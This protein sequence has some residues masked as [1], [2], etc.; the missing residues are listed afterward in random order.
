MSTIEATFADI[1]ERDPD[2]QAD[3]R[4]AAEYSVRSYYRRMSAMEASVLAAVRSGHM[5]AMPPD[6]AAI[7]SAVLN[8]PETNRGLNT[9]GILIDT[10]GRNARWLVVVVLRHGGH[11]SLPVPCVNVTPTPIP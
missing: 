7:A 2:T 1:S 11:C 8:L 6:I 4:I 5:P 10:D 3:A 9:D